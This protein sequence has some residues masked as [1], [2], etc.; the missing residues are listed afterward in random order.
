MQA[1]KAKLALLK[2]VLVNGS[3]LMPRHKLIE[4]RVEHGATL[5]TVRDNGVER[6][7]LMNADSTFLDAANATKTGL[8]YATFLLASKDANKTA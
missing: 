2:V 6:R 4:A 3:G 8:S 7:V 1:G 5:E